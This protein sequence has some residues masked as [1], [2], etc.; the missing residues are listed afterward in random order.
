MGSWARVPQR[1]NALVSIAVATSLV[2]AS[3]GGDEGGDPAADDQDAIATLLGQLR[4]AQESG[5]AELACSEIYVVQEPVRPD[6]ERAAEGEAEVEGGEGG[7]AGLGECEAAFRAAD[8]ARRREVTELSTEVGTIQVD[9]DAATAIVHTELRRA[10]GS[11]LDQDV[12][13]DLVRTSEGW[14]V[15]IA[16]EG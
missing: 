10:D 13:Y 4:S 16:E 5:D 11:A 7:E 1:R 9:G 3:C 12:P 15:R 6:A 14:R 2:A 8:A